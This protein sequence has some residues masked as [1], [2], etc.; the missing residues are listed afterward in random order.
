MRFLSP[1]STPRS[2]PRSTPARS[3]SPLSLHFSMLNNSNNRQRRYRFAAPKFYSVPHNRV[4]EEGESV[5][6][7]CTIAGH[8]VPWCECFFI[9]IFITTWPYFMTPT[10]AAL[11]LF[12]QKKY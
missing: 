9:N 11:I 3:M 6:F 5:R 8:P 4:C 7:Q 12:A 2:T 1:N 10:E